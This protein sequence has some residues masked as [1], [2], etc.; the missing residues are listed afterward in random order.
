MPCLTPPAVRIAKTRTAAVLGSVLFLGLLLLA[1]PLA[2][3]A[4][5][6]I[7]QGAGTGSNNATSTSNATTLW[8][9]AGNWSPSGPPATGDTA[10]L[11]LTNS[12]YVNA[13]T[14]TVGDLS[15]DGTTALGAL[16]VT[17][18]VTFTVKYFFDLGEESGTI[19][20]VIQDGGTS[21]S[22]GYLLIGNPSGTTGS[23]MLGG[24][25]LT[26][27]ASGGW[28][29][30]IGG[31]G[32]G[33]FI[34]TG[35]AHK[36]NGY[37]LLGDG[38]GGTGTYRL[39]GGTLEVNGREFISSFKTGIGI[40]IQTGGLHTV[41][42]EFNL[43]SDSGG[44]GSYTL[45]GGTLTVGATGG[46]GENIGELGT[47]TFTQTGGTHTVSLML[48]LGQQSGGHGSYMLGGGTLGVTGF[49]YVGSTGTGTFTQTGGTHT[50]NGIFYLGRESGSSGSY[51]LGGGAL[52][53]GTTA[54]EGEEH[55]GASG[56][57]TFTQTGGTHTVNSYLYLG[58]DSGVSGSYLLGGGTL[59]VGTPDSP[60]Y[61]Y[62]GLSGTGTFTQTGG[63]HLVN[64]ELDMAENAGSSGSYTLGGGSLTVGTPDGWGIEFI[65]RLGAVTLTQTGGKHTVNGYLY[66]GGYSGGSG[67]YLLGGGTLTIGSSGNLG[68]E[69]IG[70][71][72]TGTFTQSGGTHTVVGDMTLGESGS[73]HMYGGSLDV[74][75]TISGLGTF[76]C[77][78][79]GWLNT[80]AITAPLTISPGGTLTKTGAG[81]MTISGP[82][83]YGTASALNVSAGTV[84]L[85]TAGG[86]NTH[87]NLVVTVNNATVSVGA[88]QYLAGL[89]LANGAKGTISAVGTGVQSRT[90]K[91]NALS[92]DGTSLLDLKDNNLVVNYINNGTG[93][94]LQAV[95]AMIKS[96]GGTKTDG[97]HYDWNGT[98]GITTSSVA[99][100]GTAATY[101][102]LGVR[103]YGFNLFNQVVQPS[104]E[105]V[106]IES[107]T[108]TAGG[109]ASIVVKYT[110]VGD[111]DLDGKV[112]VNDYLNW[113][114]YYR[115]QP[116]TGYVSWMT[117]DFNYDGAINVNDYL[118]LLNA[119]RF[120]S[121]G[122]LGSGEQI[123]DSLL[124]QG[125]DATPE[126]A[127]ALMLIVGGAAVILRR[128][129]RR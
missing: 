61:E 103:D 54:E 51:T 3:Q 24:G 36:V 129:R 47:G 26:A 115:F 109:T 43:G 18:G 101:I 41:V 96:G 104:I 64:Y 63:T 120:Q 97:A 12:G 89:S 67:S 123:P 90:I 121:P 16:H 56:T 60:G 94:Q 93:S 82:T 6:H 4:D 74:S 15:L 9:T 29:E 22:D 100:T 111:M 105:G 107:S 65:G 31:L 38:S 17:D 79:G 42:D 45:G 58:S 98:R 70:S 108:N 55:I 35:G 13:Q 112:T 78:Q 28:G 118:A 44:I 114:N 122:G 73:Y 34:Q 37:L 124:S 87:R 102:G 68:V 128:R 33:T 53:I 27:G 66:V 48:C 30:I 88:T 19:G 62:I 92:I 25:T 7:W 83:S 119:Y 86:D 75:G 72:T 50:V 106:A 2:A 77:E 52:T 116:A 49:E 113:L 32:T 81:A 127:T 110:W 21:I 95:I 71:S 76:V 69:D 91:T 117:G 99:L 59:A 11:T 84:T 39:G 1:A 46:V 85:A 57:G 10:Y 23:Y 20:N 40:F 14:T 126:P 125:M 8:L 5:L 80:A